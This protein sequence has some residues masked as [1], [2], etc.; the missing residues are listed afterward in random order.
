MRVVDTS[1]WIEWF[2]DSPL[3]WTLRQQM[4]EPGSLIVPTVV[5]FELA[6]WLARVAPERASSVIGVTRNCVVVP[7]DTDLATSA[8][9]MSRI[10]TLPMADA[11]IYATVLSCD[12]DLLTCDAHFEGLPHV[13]YMAKAA[14]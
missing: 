8:A 12:A 1:A 4:P 13:V 6:K 9:H 5:Q 7:L 3:G 14:P 11:I 10:H 2:I